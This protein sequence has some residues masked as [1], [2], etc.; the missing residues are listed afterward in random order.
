MRQRQTV[1]DATNVQLES[2][3]ALIQIA[4]RYH[5]LPVAFVFDLPHPVLEAQNLSRDTSTGRKPVSSRVIGHQRRDLNR[6]L[7][8]LRR[9]GFSHVYTFES[10]ADVDGVTLS[11]VPLRCDLREQT[12]P[13]DL[14]GDVHGC[15]DELLMLLDRLGYRVERLG[16]PGTDQ[17]SWPPRWRV[18]TP[19]GRRVVFLGDLVDRGP[20]V[21]EVVTLAMQMV[22]DGQA[23][24][25]PG[26]HDMKLSRK[27]RGR[28]VTIA[29]GL[30]ESLGQLEGTSDQFRAEVAT[31][32]DGLTAHLV[33]DGGRLVAAHAG[34]KASMQGRASPAVR[35]FALF[36]ETTGEI[37]TYG[38]PVRLDWAAEYSGRAT[39]VY[40]HTPVPTAEWVNGTIDVDTGCVF[41][42][43]LS[44]LRYPEREIVSVL[45]NAVYCQ[46]V[47]PLVA[48]G[49]A[50]AEPGALDTH[51]LDIA[52]L[53]GKQHIE[54]R[55]LGRIR[56]GEGEAAAALETVSR[57]AVDPR[58]LIYAPPTMSPP[59]TSP[60]PDFLEHPDEAFAFYRSRGLDRVIC[61]KKHM[62][63]RAIVIVLRRPDVAISRFGFK[64]PHDGVVYSRNG[65]AFFSDGEMEAAVLERMRAAVESAGLFDGL[66]TD[67]LC[68]DTEILPWSIK[69]HALIEQQYA[70]TGATALRGL[71]AAV[72]AVHASPA[73]EPL[74][75][76]F[77]AR[78]SRVQRYDHAW[79]PYCWAVDGVADVR[80]APFHLLA[81][82]GRTFF[83]ETHLWHIEQIDRL[84]TAAPDLIEPTPYQ[85]V[86]FGDTG[87]PTSPE[88]AIEWWLQHTSTDG[89]GM[90]VKPWRFVQTFPAEGERGFL[91]PAIKVRGREYLRII[92]GPEYDTP[93][94][95]ER[96]RS[97]AVQSKRRLALAEFALGAEGLSLF[98]DQAALRRVHACVFGVLALESESI[99]PRL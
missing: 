77:E 69:A 91:Q 86:D 67:W 40:G 13:F 66:K 75:A 84:V 64:T 88:A 95:M 85:V 58:W 97:R 62:G 29:H 14:I 80:V 4:R 51:A 16:E 17:T 27:L 82:Q 3:R 83:D 47:R 79:R 55:L 44:A 42:G 70:L 8:T 89:E 5:A 23:L 71:S 9:E 93:E 73:A 39:V 2:R 1:V 31:F 34:M 28:D 99:D 92:Y 50:A 37:D 22:R 7:K 19:P 54:T 90:V 12:G 74:R 49:I 94:H 43:S 98:V 10:T 32:F 35:D 76:H 46:P 21:V 25:V 53:L 61:Q 78:L 81:A 63:S 6:G 45:S 57:M 15:I 60:R 56:I 59:E 30:A 38:L 41:G 26:N 68:L 18:Q 65:R 48:Q 24:C 11:R 20:G 33:L 52:D 87:G 36:G 72:R 96:L